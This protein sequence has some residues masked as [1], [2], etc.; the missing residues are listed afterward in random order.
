MA[1]IIQAIYV[2]PTAR[3]ALVSVP[4]VR[5]L[6]GKGLEG[7]RYALGVG[8]FSRWPGTGREVT[9][10][11][12]EVITAAER[13]FGLNLS[14]GRSR[15]N[16]VTAGVRL[17][18]LMGKTFRVGTA[19][20]HGDRPADPCAY[21]DRIVGPGVLA[22]LRGRGGLRAA[23]VR[24]GVLRVGDTIEVVSRTIPPSE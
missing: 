6:A 23:I 22:A 16:L 9:L 7:D 19:V 24:D 15:R 12:S 20:L 3:E 1:G 11:E 18:E 21:L 5:A 8:S 17:G 10:I 4:E 2:A 14:D 13:E